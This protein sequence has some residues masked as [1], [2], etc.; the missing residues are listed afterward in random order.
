MGRDTLVIGRTTPDHMAM[1][2]G[3]ITAPRF[4]G[5]I[6]MVAFIPLL[7]GGG[8]SPAWPPPPSS[9]AAIPK[10][11]V[12]RR[13]GSFHP[14]GSDGEAGC[15]NHDRFQTKLVKIELEI[16]LSTMAEASE[17]KNLLCLYL[18]AVASLKQST[19]EGVTEAGTVHWE[20]VA[21][22]GSPADRICIVGI[23]AR[24]PRTHFR[25]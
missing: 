2:P 11:T 13:D 1:A 8:S 18:Y 20:R 24:V 12:T 25:R 5:L 4:I 10:K 21:E 6:A 3:V 9:S 23:E 16:P 22:N 17:L 7:Y 15:K 19:A 14:G